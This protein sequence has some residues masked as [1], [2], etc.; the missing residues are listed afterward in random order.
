MELNSIYLF[1]NK[2]QVILNENVLCK[3]YE[4]R[5]KVNVF[6]K[7]CVINSAEKGLV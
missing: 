2:L 5:G 1:R 4:L 7:L 6:K 3:F